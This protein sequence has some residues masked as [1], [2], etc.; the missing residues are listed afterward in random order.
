MSDPLDRLKTALA[1]RYTIE[2]ELGRGGM[3]V[4]YLA[5][6]V[7]HGRHV[8][9]KVLLP[10][11][12]ATL[13]GDRFLQEI[14]VTANLQHPHILA[15]YDSGEADG[16]LYYVMP[17]V[18]GE[19]LRDRLKREKQL[20]VDDALRIA[21][22]V[23]SALDFAH[24]HE[25]IHRDIK[26]E[27]ILLHEGE[28]MVADFGIA[29][30]VKAAGG[31]RLTETGL[32]IGTPEY[33]SPEQVAG[34][35]SIDARS[36]LY[37]LA[38]VLYEMLAGDP[39]FVASNP[40]AV[41]AKHMTDPA[42]PITTVRSS[43]PR[44]VAVAITKAL[45]KA[46]AD[47]FAS[48]KAFSEALFATAVEDEKEKK[49]IVVL[50]FENLS[51]DP[52][53]AFFADGLTEELIADLSKVRALRVISRTSA[54]Q[55]K[56]TTKNVP[57]VARE[58]NVR[59]LLEGSVRRAGSNL[60]ITAQLID[61]KADAHL[62]AEKYSGTLDDVFDLQE[63]LS[64][65]IVA[66]LRVSLTSDEDHR[67]ADRPI[68]D[69]RAYDAFLLARHGL[70]TWSKQGI[71]SAIV[72]L[73]NA[74]Q[75]IGDNA[76]LCAALGYAYEVAYDSGFYHDE[77]TLV[78][79]EQYAAKALELDPEL[80]QAHYA[81]GLVQYK[82]GG[83]QAFMRS[84]K[85]AVEVELIPDALF[86]LGFCLAEVG[87]IEEAREYADEAVARDPL[88]YLTVF[89]RGFVETLAGRCEDG[90]ERI[91]VARERLAPGDPF[92]GWGL[93][94]ALAYAGREKEAHA[95]CQQVA[96]TDSGMWSDHCALLKCALEQDG[97][98]VLQVLAETDVRQVARTDEWYP[99]ILADALTHVGE[100]DEALDWV[101]QAISW[102]FTNYQFLSQHNRFLAPLRGNV[103]F[104][105]LM[106][107]A[108]QKQE[109][110]EI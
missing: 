12:A 20:P 18:E 92:S 50:P 72:L 62:W 26:P 22:Q 21:Q 36:D 45:G 39:P 84:A 86:F 1:D 66:E 60:R 8:A 57:A 76:V 73:N 83:M 35:R 47:R 61:A 78:R 48:A 40:R 101:E 95:L 69:P 107:V 42:P 105:R 31:E 55:Y 24:R 28:A 6:D 33:M 99:V 96:A 9:V 64:R 29:L 103:R 98:G 30:A 87:K 65:E 74:L 27:N 85:R 89:V 16:L 43:V 70:L 54:M 3:A 41:L 19:S 100:T 2:H 49:S 80:P 93:A 13:G 106:E 59:Y 71:D 77:E 108:R 109:A 102:G 11:L 25:V 4:V 7:R 68:A 90:V 17:Y 52:D 81:L 91:R 23:A 5:E 51:P 38:C 37:S 94:H 110:F 58:L 79:A 75:T 88:T 44:P 56:G 46:P 82:R 104:Q 34:E 53:N 14:R 10:E 67:L 97:D 63:R 32:S 15:L